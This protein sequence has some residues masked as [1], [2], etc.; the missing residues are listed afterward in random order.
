MKNT[1]EELL[2][3]LLPEAQGEMEKCAIFRYL[4]TE[5]DLLYDSQS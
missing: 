1:K 2:C 5:H 4:T 3:N